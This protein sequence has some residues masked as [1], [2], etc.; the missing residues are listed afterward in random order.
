MHIPRMT[1]MSTSF[2]QEFDE[3]TQRLN[4][5]VLAAIAKDDLCI[6]YVKQ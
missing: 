6:P 2:S 4:V 3:L 1:L 5:Q